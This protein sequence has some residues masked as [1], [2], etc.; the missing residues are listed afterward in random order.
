MTNPAPGFRPLGAHG[1]PRDP[2]ERPRLKRECRLHQKSA[3]RPMLSLIRG[4]FV[5]WDRPQ[6]DAHI[7]DKFEAPEGLPSQPRSGMAF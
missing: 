5:F 3:R 4:H 6:K 7:N 1:G 2:L